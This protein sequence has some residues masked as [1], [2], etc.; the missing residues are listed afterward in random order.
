M[1]LFLNPIR[2]LIAKFSQSLR[3]PSKHKG[4]SHLHSIIPMPK[5][6]DESSSKRVLSGC[7]VS[8]AWPEALE[9]LEMTSSYLQKVTGTSWSAV[10][11]DEAPTIHIELDET[12]PAEGYA[13]E[14]LEDKMF[15]SASDTIGVLYGLSS[16][17]RCI[18]NS[19]G[20][21]HVPSSLSISDH[22]TNGWRGIHIDVA[23]NFFDLSVLYG[24]V[25]LFSF[26]KI[27]K[28]HLHLTD[29]QGWRFESIKYP[30]LH[31]RGSVRRET[32][33]GKHFP[34]F[35]EAYLGDKKSV[36]GYYTQA[37]L[38]DLDSYA[39]KRGVEI[40]PEIDIPGHATSALISYPEHAANKA[41]KEIVTYWGIF[42]NVFS[43][44]DPSINFLC[45]IFDELTSVFSSKYIHI[46]GDEVPSKNYKKDPTS[47]SLVSSGIVES[48]DKID[49]YIL[50]KV[51]EHIVSIGKVP[52]LW[53][54]GRE[55][56]IKHSGVTMVWR[57]SRYAKEVLV[58]GGT[59][60]L[61]P[62]SHFYFDYYQKTPETEPLAIGGYLPLEQVYDY[63]PPEPENG[64]VLGIQANLWT[65]Y[66]Q[67]PKHLHYMLL[68]R[69]YAL[70]EVAWGTNNNA[71]DF[72]RRV[73][74]Q[75]P[76]S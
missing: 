46:G 28:F 19:N 18:E 33:V 73:S 36:S 72:F 27:N 21:L 34:F 16:L 13:L 8:S 62:T 43:P 65:E 26:Y 29:D 75:Q 47:K 59:V 38:R 12:I 57:D 37:E 41:P 45:D 4:V 69:L 66:I 58:R 1:R 22:P 9:T 20:V 7:S 53:D 44:S 23:R 2:G 3:L 24:L 42:N 64:T 52:V 51:A 74:K 61:C 49:T 48:F 67:T 25:D 39:S 63:T 10:K 32:V 60:V 11:L 31:E 71:K 40:I 76:L 5:K 55:V 56:A 17:S 6:I 50:D 35:G 68:P 14:A 54:E 70:S 15:L 30:L